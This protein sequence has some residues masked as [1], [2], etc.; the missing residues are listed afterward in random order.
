MFNAE[1]WKND[2]LYKA[3]HVCSALACKAAH[4][5]DGTDGWEETDLNV[6]SGCS[7]CKYCYGEPF[8]CD[9]SEL[10]DD[11]A[12]VMWELIQE[13]EVFQKKM[14]EQE[15]VQVVWKFA[16]PHCPVCGQ[17]LPEGDRVKYCLHCGRAVT[18]N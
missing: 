12:D 9:Y 10:L 15:P 13:H 18:W 5:L 17:M 1:K 6:K 11:A 8:D 2:V 14:K 3:N 7:D 4:G 16:L